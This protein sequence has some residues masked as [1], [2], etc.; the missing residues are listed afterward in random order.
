MKLSFET[1]R[2]LEDSG[3]YKMV[4][5]DGEAHL[6]YYPPSVEEASGENA[7]IVRTMEIRLRKV[8]DGY[9]ILGGEV[10][11]NGEVLREI[12]LDELELWFQFL[13]G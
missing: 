4:E 8:E 3:K 6:V 10:K 2:R 12:K 9:E 5:S 13:E 1:V 11:E 7:D